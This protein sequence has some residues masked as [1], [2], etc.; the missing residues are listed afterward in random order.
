MK[1]SEAVVVGKALAKVYFKMYIKT[2]KL[3]N[4][5]LK[6]EIEI[7]GLKENKET[8]YYKM[9]FKLP[10]LDSVLC[11]IDYNISGKRFGGYIFNKVEI[12]RDEV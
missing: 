4:T 11:V 9:I 6:D 7:I 3:K 1:K 2:F 10:K 12:E 8:K 5:L